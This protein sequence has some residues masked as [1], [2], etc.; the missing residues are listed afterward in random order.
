MEKPLAEI[1]CEGLMI[2]YE[3]SHSWLTLLS[4]SCDSEGVVTSVLFELDEE[5]IEL[6]SDNG[7]RISNHK[8]VVVFVNELARTWCKIM[9]EQLMSTGFAS[10]SEARTKIN[11]M[12]WAG[13]Y[14]DFAID[15]LLQVHVF[16]KEVYV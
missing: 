16:G 1:I 3:Q 13:N 10:V 9:T 12:I 4:K 6:A 5:G 15:V 2:H 14:S 7:Y 11:E 8:V